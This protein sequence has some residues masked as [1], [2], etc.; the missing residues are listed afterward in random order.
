MQAWSALVLVLVLVLAWVV[1]GKVHM[2]SMDHAYVR[3]WFSCI[4]G[5][6][7]LAEVWSSSCWLVGA[8]HLAACRCGAGGRQRPAVL[9]HLKQLVRS[10][11]VV[12]NGD[13]CDGELSSIIQSTWLV[14]RETPP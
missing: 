3:H 9:L 5:S 11:T 8:W 14:T 13:A 7:L 1:F 2:R 10:R 6:G 4:V 12:A